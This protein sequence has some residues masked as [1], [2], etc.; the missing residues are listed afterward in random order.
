MNF[1][2]LNINFFSSFLS[3]KKENGSDQLRRPGKNYGINLSKKINNSLFGN[4]NFNI[5]YNHYGKHFDTH[6]VNFSTVEMDSTDIID[7]IIARELE[8]SNFFIKITNAFDE[9]YQR[10]HGYNQEK[11]NIK[12][13]MRY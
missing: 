10:P 12:F 2:N 8:N 3:S 13:G 9:T 11:R 4:L 1:K 5:K 6:A 7:I